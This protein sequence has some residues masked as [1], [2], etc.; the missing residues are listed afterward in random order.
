MLISRKPSFLR[1][2]ECRC[3]IDLGSAL[4]L[5]LPFWIS[6]YSP[7]SNRWVSVSSAK[8]SV[9]G[10]VVSYGLSGGYFGDNEQRVPISYPRNSRPWSRHMKRGPNLER[11]IFPNGKVA[12]EMP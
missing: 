1:S 9:S 6:G 12:C 10:D 4:V 7:V 3:S 5:E 11:S 2:K 8:Q